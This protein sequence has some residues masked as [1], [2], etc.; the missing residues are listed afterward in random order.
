MK[1]LTGLSFIVTLILASQSLAGVISIVPHGLYCQGSK[2][3]LECL[4]KGQG[5]NVE[6]SKVTEVLLMSQIDYRNSVGELKSLGPAIRV[7]YKIG[8]SVNDIIV[9]SESAS[10]FGITMMELMDSFKDSKTK[11]ILRQEQE[12]RIKLGVVLA[13][14]K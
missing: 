12:T 2:S 14:S 5:T 6:T 3:D 7:F 4:S 11:V 13:I 1:S 8:N 10:K 9:T